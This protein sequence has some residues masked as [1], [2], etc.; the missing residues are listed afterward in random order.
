MRWW[1]YDYEWPVIG[2]I[3]LAV[4]GLGCVG[5]HL[6]IQ[7]EGKS[8][9]VLDLIFKS[10]QLFVLQIS[11]DPPMPWQLNTARVLAPLVAAYTALQALAELFAAQI[12][13]LR[14]R[15]RCGHVVICGLGRKGLILARGFLER[16]RTVVVIEQ[17]AENDL[18]RQ[19]R[20]LG[21]GVLL[22]TRPSRG[23]SARRAFPVPR[24]SSPS[25]ATMAQTPKSPCA[26][27]SSWPGVPVRP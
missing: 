7:R 9:D 19:C 16:G 17:D 4:V 10:C 6:H 25:A 8:S 20:D 12:Q 3:A 22:A 2:A 26:P 1:W 11:V 18:V 5:F 21:G 27:R 15:F 14:L 23:C 13:S 24:I